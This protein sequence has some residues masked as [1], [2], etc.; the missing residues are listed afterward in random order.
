[1]E[2]EITLNESVK[3]AMEIA[4]VRLMQKKDINK[5][6]VTE[7][8]EAAGVGRSSFYRN[9][10]SF[11]DVAVSYINRIYRDYFNEKPVNPDIYKKG[12]FG[13]FL[14]ERFR[15]IKK[16][17]EFF[18]AVNKSGMLYGIMKRMDSEIKAKFLVA[19][20]SDSRYFS[21]MIMGFTAGMIE[22]W[23]EGGMKESEDE[24]AEIVKACLLGTVKNLKDAF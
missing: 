24:M 12:I 10:E 13:A 3:E 21:A 23:I 20:I 9:F 16:N 17:R 5:I 7:L 4:L 2:N 6:K 22:E 14:R 1:M 19:D 18:S 8:C 11:E 15:F